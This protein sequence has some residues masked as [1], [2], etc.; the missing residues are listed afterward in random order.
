MR[1]VVTGATGLIGRAL[2]AELLTQGDQVVALSRGAEHAR[3]RLSAGVEI[4]EWRDPKGSPPPT[5]ALSGADA[6]VHLLGEPIAQRWSEKT[7]REIRDSRVL[8]TNM[9]T[10][11]LSGLGEHER[12]AVL[13]SQSATGYYGNRAEEE[14]TESSPPG[15]DFLALLTVEWERAAG[16]APQGTRVVFARTGVVLA[17]GE[18][19]LAK[20]L[21]PFKLGVGGPVAGGR[22]YVPWIALED[23]V[24]AL[25][26]CLKADGLS[27]PVNLTA[28]RAVTNAE[29]SKALGRALHR[30]AILPVPG[31]ALRALYGEMAQVVTG[32]QRVLPARLTESGFSWRQPK[33][34]PALLAALGRH[35]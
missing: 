17:P 20:M 26:A 10:A 29:L 30:P 11:A 8:A 23:E 6:V 32:G 3:R 16:A 13:V 21:P 9:L 4:R 33:L 24:A 7:R 5:E 15:E 31:L 18:G 14:L 19:A 12:P 34:E 1:V 25:I 27:G 2:I 35:G 28:P 22:Q